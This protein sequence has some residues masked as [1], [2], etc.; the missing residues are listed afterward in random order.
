MAFPL[1]SAFYALALFVACAGGAVVARAQDVEDFDVAPA[2]E[3]SA[4]AIPVQTAASDEGEPV[5]APSK[6]SAP[7]PA[8]AAPAAAPSVSAAA[9]APSATPPVTDGDG[10]KIHLRK[11]SVNDRLFGSYR[12]RVGAARPDFNDGLKFYKELYGTARAFP[13]IGVDWFPWDWYATLGLSFRFGYY[14]AEGYAALP[15][16]GKKKE[17]YTASDIVQDKN[18]PLSL[19]LI[20]MQA[21]ASAEFTPFDGKWVVVDGWIGF[22]RLYWQEVRTS[23]AEPTTKKGTGTGAAAESSDDALV[24]KGSTNET[25]IGAAINILLNPLDQ[26]SA[27]SG[28]GTLGIESVYLSPY[29]QIVKTLG[30]G[31]VSFGRTELGLSFTFETAR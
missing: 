8:A 20:P 25:A 13:M 26:V 30:S 28:R 21:A 11:R 10:S 7:P 22:E 29:I 14:S 1:P 19:T 17:A 15:V 12:I 31:G 2:G 4:E 27:K 5:Q 18:G 6:V 23:I 3:V 9:A 24:N 16:A